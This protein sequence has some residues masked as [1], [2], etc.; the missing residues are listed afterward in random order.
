M[1]NPIKQKQRKQVIVKLTSKHHTT[2][3]PNRIEIG[4]YIIF[5]LICLVTPLIFL[6]FYLDVGIGCA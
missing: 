4:A 2:F 3:P 5:L 6:K 1:I